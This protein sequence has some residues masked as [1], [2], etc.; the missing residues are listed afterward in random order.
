MSTMCKITTYLIIL[1]TIYGCA[2]TSP[3]I[4]KASGSGDVSTIKRLRAE[5][6]NINERDHAGATAL[7]YAIWSKKPDVAKYLI[8]SG[9]DI[10]AKDNNGFDALIYAVDYGQPEIINILINKGADIE[11][12]DNSGMTPLAHAVWQ[13]RDINAV[14]QLIKK[15]ADVNTKIS[16]SETLLDYALAIDGRM[17]IIIELVS[18][19]A[20]LLDPEDGKARLLFIGEG[21]LLRDT[22]V[23]IGDRHK[24]LK[25]GRIAFIDVNP[26]RHTIDIPVSG[27]QAPSKASVDVKAG[28]IF[29]FTVSP[30]DSSVAILGLGVA[31]DL[32]ANILIAGPGAAGS[33][34][35]V[36]VLITPLEESVAKEKIQALLK[37]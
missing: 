14:K 19:G 23:T 36:D 9:A 31:V 10:K 26:G 24:N 13:V 35:P 8:E 3:S 4:I 37:L 6:R 11:S 28:E 32:L 7:M 20:R 2:S 5:G 12:R 22:W 1:F 25:K 16:E 30:S 18:S 17:D 29:Y 15:G 21:F 27:Y 33:T 34:T